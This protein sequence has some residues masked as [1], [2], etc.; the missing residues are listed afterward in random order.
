MRLEEIG[1]ENTHMET[2]PHTGTK[3]LR[4]C[5]I[6]LLQR[7]LGMEFDIPILTKNVKHKM[8]IAEAVANIKPWNRKLHREN[9]Y[10][11]RSTQ[12]RGNLGSNKPS[13]STTQNDK[14]WWELTKCRGKE[15]TSLRCWNGQKSGS[16]LGFKIMFF[17]W[18]P[19]SQ[20]KPKLVYH[21]WRI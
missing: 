8:R 15:K 10:T 4:Q 7:E 12:T 3:A 13:Y 19:I 11:R 9:T 16:V 1:H 18:G 6:I 20:P 21:G 17:V 14:V 5:W 2:T